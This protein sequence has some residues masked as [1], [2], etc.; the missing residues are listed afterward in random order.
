MYAMNLYRRPLTLALPPT[1]YVVTT[2]PLHPQPRDA[3][4]SSGVSFV[5]NK[6]TE[7]SASADLA[8]TLC[9]PQKGI[10]ERLLERTNNALLGALHPTS[11]PVFP[12]MVRAT[13]RR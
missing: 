3:G 6:R 11:S 1:R 5:A 4:R 12:T 9:E 8:S 7:R 13:R 10:A 2:F